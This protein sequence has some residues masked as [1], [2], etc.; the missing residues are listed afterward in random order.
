[1][2][3]CHPSKNEFTIIRIYIDK[4]SS[5]SDEYWI[6]WIDLIFLAVFSVFFVVS[7]YNVCNHRSGPHASN[8][9]FNFSSLNL[10][11]LIGR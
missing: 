3:T 1:M 5:V 11:C 4:I 6:V 10:T 2:F 9:A 8:S 7:S